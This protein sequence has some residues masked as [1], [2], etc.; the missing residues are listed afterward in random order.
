LPHVLSEE[1]GLL[2]AWTGGPSVTRTVRV[3]THAGEVEVTVVAPFQEEHP[4]KRAP[5]DLLADLA[6]LESDGD[7]IDGRARTALEDE[8]VRRFLES[9]EASVLSEVG[10]CHFV[11]DFAADYFG[12]TIATLEP[13]QLREIVFEL[14]P[15]KVS[16]DASR[17]SWIVEENRALYA[18][19][20]RELGLAQADACLRVLGGKAVEQLE[21]ALSDRQNFGMAKSVW[22]AGRDAGFDM[23]SKEGIEAFMRVTQGKPLPVGF[24][25]PAALPPR[26][27]G[28]AAASQK[29]SQRKAARKARKKGR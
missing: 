26:R 23:S 4:R 18:F 13:A 14:I 29:K 19:M 6:D 24:P 7:E 10:S 25:S 15:R 12:A 9:P 27:P 11:M 21:A 1:A 3:G 22:M 17:A 5:G 8:L 2:A 16:I 28:R 20:K